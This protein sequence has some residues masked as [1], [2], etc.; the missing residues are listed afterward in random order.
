MG[1]NRGNSGDAVYQK[2]KNAIR[3]RYI[4][5][6]S[7]LI[8]ET[9]AEKLGVSR[10]P[11]RSSIKQLEAEGLVYTVR[12]RGAFIITPTFE[13]IEE[14]FFVRGQLEQAAARLAAE[15]ITPTQIKQ[16]NKLVEKEK[17]IFNQ[18]DLDA[19]YDINDALHSRIAEISGNKVLGTYVKELLDKTRIYLILFDP[20]SKLVLS[21]TL[22]AHHSI[23]NALANHDPVQ[24]SMAVEA[25]IKSSVENLETDAVDLVPDDYLSI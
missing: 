5:Q 19:Y 1:E 4:K 6:G 16:L 13:E 3:K 25:H 14:T 7:Q 17:S 2:L 20:F 9:L 23:I 21:P 12:N 15:R 24:A 18:H 22:D 11:V 10:T 8:E